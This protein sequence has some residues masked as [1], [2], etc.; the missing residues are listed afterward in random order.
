LWHRGEIE[1][2]LLMIGHTGEISGA[3]ELRNGCILSWSHDGTLRIWD[4][5][6]GTQKNVLYA[7][8]RGGQL[9]DGAIE[10]SSGEVLFWAGNDGTLRFWDL[11]SD[12]EEKV[13]LLEGEMAM[14]TG[15]IEISNDEILFWSYDGD[16]WLWNM[17]TGVD[18][19]VGVGHDDN[20]NGILRLDETR[21][22]SWSDDRRLHLWCLRD[23]HSS[24]AVVGHSG[25][26]NGAI[27][28]KDGR[29]VSWSDDGTLRVWD[30]NSGAEQAVLFGHEKSVRGAIEL[31][32]GRLVSW[33]WDDVICWWQISPLDAAGAYPALSLEESRPSTTD[34]AVAISESVSLSCGLG[35]SRIAPIRFYVAPRGHPQFLVTSGG[36]W[37]A[38][39]PK[40]PPILLREVLPDHALTAEP[41]TP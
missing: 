14:I 17:E 19:P 30:R 1:P 41:R 26:V 23:E 38:L 33:A 29:I 16:F 32:D 6:N 5:G 9:I 25:A 22:L 2:P 4:A 27:Q 21:F 35:P 8:L 15:A 20:I 37:L 13:I 28:L 34:S 24:V 18:E 31:L 39:V 3:L 11:A 40:C 12:S 7:E 10:L 36:H